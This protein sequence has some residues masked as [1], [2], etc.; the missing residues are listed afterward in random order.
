MCSE[1]VRSSR[2]E[3]KDEDIAENE[4]P[5][6][7]QS[8]EEVEVTEGK[9]EVSEPK[10]KE[11][12]KVGEKEDEKKED[13]TEDNEDE[14]KDDKNEEKKDV[15]E[16]SAKKEE[17]AKKAVKKEDKKLDKKAEA[18]DEKKGGADAKKKESGKSL[19][20]SNLSS[21]TRA[22]DLKTRFTQYGKVSIGHYLASLKCG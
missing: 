11:K 17:P 5:A 4:E 22:A 7:G 6:D 3:S 10:G 8:G 2:A 21:M 9:E 13:K 15:K 14:N 16:K 18:K 1:C 20:V 19:W 12:D